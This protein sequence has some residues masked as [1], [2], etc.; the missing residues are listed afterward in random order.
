MT[1]NEFKEYSESY[2][3]IPVYETISGD[4]ISPSLIYLKLRNHSENSFLFE[5]VDGIGTVARYSFLGIDPDKIISNTGHKVNIKSRDKTEIIEKNIFQIL[6]NEIAGFKCFKDKNLPY[7]TSG[8]IGYTGFENFSLIEDSVSYIPNDTENI[9]DAIYCFYSSLIIFDHYK[10]QIFIVSSGYTGD[11]SDPE[12]VYQSCTEKIKRLKNILK[13]PVNYNPSFSFN[14]D[15]TNSLSDEEFCDVVKR[16]KERIIEGDIY[17]VVPSIKY[18]TEYEGDL[19]S[20]Y[21]ALRI[22]NPTPYMHYIEFE[23]GVKIA[24]SSP[25]DLLKIKENKAT[26]LPIAGTKKRGTDEENDLRNETELL[27]DPKEVSEH[28]MLVDLARNDLGRICEYDSVKVTENMTVKKYS[29]VMHMVS[30]VEGFLKK[31]VSIIDAIKYCFPAGTVSG[32]PKISAVKIINELENCKRNIYAGAIGYID[33][34]KNLDLCIAIR[35]FFSF[36]NKLFWQAG[37]GVV[38]DSV[39]EN[40]LDECKNKAEVMITAL[41]F[42]E[43][44]NENSYY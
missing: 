31:D 19:F 6:E 14:R 1:L 35:T 13:N 44:L 37:A 38:A 23:N 16:C 43:G 32:A 5:S 4:L 24:G 40:E 2:N 29:H 3:F 12:I 33:T 28:K 17:Q 8:F 20:T 9:P 39:P 11:D 34:S 22:I 10:N 27:N 25:E 42:A 21:R 18:N 26:V 30:R 15:I 7:F 36:N 41:N